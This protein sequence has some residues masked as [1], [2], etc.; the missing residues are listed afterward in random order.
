MPN[1][2]HMCRLVA[3]YPLGIFLATAWLELLSAA[4]IA[5]E[6]SRSLDFLETDSSR[7]PPSSRPS[8]IG[9]M[10]SGLA[11]SPRTRREAWVMSTRR[12]A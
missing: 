8:A 11:G 7:P 4:E 3:G 2:I 9:A 6:I 5:D 12:G 1:V 10:R